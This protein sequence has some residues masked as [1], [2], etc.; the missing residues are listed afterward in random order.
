MTE[1][2]ERQKIIQEEGAGKGGDS[3]QNLMEYPII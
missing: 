1:T 3:N 2:E